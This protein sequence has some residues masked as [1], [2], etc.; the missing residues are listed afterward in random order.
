MRA[1]G[2]SPIRAIRQAARVSQAELASRLGLSRTR[3]TRL[4]GQGTHVRWDT[5]LRVAEACHVR[6]ELALT[7]LATMTVMVDANEALHNG[8][9]G[10]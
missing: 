8:G 6:V 2:L 9:A 4:E 5:V 7:P 1:P 3:V 10:L